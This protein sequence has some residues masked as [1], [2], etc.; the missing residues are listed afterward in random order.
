M[1]KL[2]IVM[3]IISTSPDQSSVQILIRKIIYTDN[4]DYIDDDGKYDTND[5]D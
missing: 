1:T 5:D 2:M 4:D 3:M